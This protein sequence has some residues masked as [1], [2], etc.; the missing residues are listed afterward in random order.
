MT[1]SVHA[2]F[3]QPSAPSP[4]DQS[5]MLDWLAATGWVVAVA[6]AH[7]G[8]FLAALVLSGHLEP[9][10]GTTAPAQLDTPRFYEFEIPAATRP[11]AI[12]SPSSERSP[13]TPSEPTP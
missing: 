5:V 6:V 2:P 9:W 3:L 11:E 4:A 12:P 7:G 13:A 10:S 1:E 8:W